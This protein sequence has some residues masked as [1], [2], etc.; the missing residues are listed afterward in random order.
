MG[1]YPA[2]TPSQHTLHLC[3]VFGKAERVQ[4]DII[5][6]FLF[7]RRHGCLATRAACYRVSGVLSVTARGTSHQVS[8]G[9]STSRSA[10]LCT[11]PDFSSTNSTSSRQASLPLLI[12]FRGVFWCCDFFES[13]HLS[14]P[15]WIQVQ[16]RSLGLHPYHDVCKRSRTLAA[17][18]C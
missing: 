10:H 4:Y 6:K 2:G 5:M 14:C 15:E 18:T 9:N 8:S 1:R 11:S 7:C 12:L 16:V 3:S 17:I 13:L